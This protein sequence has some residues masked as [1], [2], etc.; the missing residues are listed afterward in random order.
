MGPLVVEYELAL[1]VTF[2]VK[3][4]GAHDPPAVFHQNMMGRPSRVRR[5]A[6]GFLQAGQPVPLQKWTGPINH[7]IPIRFNAD[8]KGID[9]ADGQLAHG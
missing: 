1:A 8:G 6:A 4:A 3:G 7:G 2:Q 5:N 9:N